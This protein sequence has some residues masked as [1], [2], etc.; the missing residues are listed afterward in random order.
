MKFIVFDCFA[1][2]AHFKKPDTIKSPDSYLIPTR[3]S[4]TGMLGCMLGF[5]K[6]EFSKIWNPKNSK[7]CVGINKE[8]RKELFTFNYR[9]VKDN[10][11]SYCGST[12]AR[13]QHVVTPNYRLY[14]SHNDVKT[15]DMLKTYVENNWSKYQTFLGI[16]EHISRVR[17]IG[18]YEAIEKKEGKK[19]FIDSVIQHNNIKKIH[20]GDHNYYTSEYMP[21]VMNSKRESLEY[22]KYWFDRSGKS[23]Q[24]DVNKYFNVEGNLV[25]EM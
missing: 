4:L 25:C 21:R 1:R 10:K 11:G 13:T 9:M 23:I 19:V 8:L 3:S 7:I 17:F 18:E 15:H 24:V 2:F 6:K 16:S 14:V 20:V 22:A 5:S 12:L